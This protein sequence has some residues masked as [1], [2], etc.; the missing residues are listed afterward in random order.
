MT[1]KILYGSNNIDDAP[2]DFSAKEKF[3]SIFY[4][5]GNA[6]FLRAL[7][8]HIPQAEAVYSWRDFL[9]GTDTIVLSMANFINPYTDVTLEARVL[10]QSNA[11]RIVL[12]GCG[13]QANSYD[14]VFELRPDTRRFLSIVGERSRSIGV[15]GD[16]SAELL[17]RQGFKNVKVIGCPSFFLSG[18]EAPSTRLVSHP[19]RIV[20][21]ATP[22]GDFRQEIRMLYDFAM[23]HGASYFL[24]GEH[25]LLGLFSETASK[26]EAD[27]LDFFKNYYCPDGIDSQVFLQWLAQNSKLFFKTDEW[28]A[29][30]REFD[31]SIGTRI[32]GAVAA[33]MSGC[34]ALTLVHDTRTQELC[35]L[36]HLPFIDLRKF[37]PSINPE[38][39]A[40]M[41]SF[42][43]FRATYPR[44]LASYVDFLKENGLNTPLAETSEQPCPLPHYAEPALDAYG[45]GEATQIRSV[46]RLMAD[47][48]SEPTFSRLDGALSMIRGNGRSCLRMVNESDRE[49][50]HIENRPTAPAP[51]DA[52]PADAELPQDQCDASNTRPEENPKMTDPTNADVLRETTIGK[53]REFQIALAEYIRETGNN[54]EF[55]L[56]PATASVKLN[57]AKLIGAELLANRCAIIERL[58]NEGE[59]CEVGTQTGGFAKFIL[60]TCP[61]VKLH[62]IDIDYSL[63]DHDGM[64]PFKE[65]GRLHTIEG[66]S[67]E[68][69]A[70]FPEEHFSWIYIDASHYYDHV[71]RDLESA[72]TRVRV[73]GHIVC[74]DYTTWSP[75]EGSPY[76]VLQA[77]NEF[78]AEEDFAVTHFAF[79]PFG[80]HDIAMRRLS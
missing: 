15:R 30:L 43:N 49:P 44:R 46:L 48:R 34:P 11:E 40:E 71:K 29:A 60:T 51:R 53:L 32:H 73:G 58:A 41:C 47:V 24:Q 68:E 55:I 57:P 78:I 36:F 66:C 80:Y 12:V 61:N 56:G 70:K 38:R 69:L 63:F 1:V 14:E 77:V 28:I 27:D 13:A 22:S 72:K 7:K 9:K 6:L 52:E 21:N 33:I 79:H 76:G 20:I 39:F 23:H 62:T 37:D 19:R 26:Q 18:S 3:K 65:A 17:N 45:I 74:N 5:T 16:Y 54:P 10:Q 2:A 75:F 35:E 42:Q 67:W 64:T 4:N 8:Q 59:V 25:H 50:S 31:L